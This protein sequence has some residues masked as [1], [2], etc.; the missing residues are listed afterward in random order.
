MF[1]KES[2]TIPSIKYKSCYLTTG[3][4]SLMARRK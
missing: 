4:L 3:S 2:I 1:C